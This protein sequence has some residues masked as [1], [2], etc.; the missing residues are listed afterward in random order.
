MVPSTR[1][2]RNE[3]REPT[4]RRAQ[5]PDIAEIK[6]GAENTRKPAPSSRFGRERRDLAGAH[7]F[8]FRPASS[9]SRGDARFSPLSSRDLPRRI[10]LPARQP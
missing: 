4:R 7:D 10:S 2:E 9:H 8:I 1:R 3:R 6:D 5:S